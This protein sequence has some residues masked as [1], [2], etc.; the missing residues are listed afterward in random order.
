MQERIL[1]NKGLQSKYCFIQQEAFQE[2][3][4]LVSSNKRKLL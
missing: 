2:Q 3:S 1:T 4:S